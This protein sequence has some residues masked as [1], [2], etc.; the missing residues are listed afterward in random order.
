MVVP[1]SLHLSMQPLGIFLHDQGVYG[2]LRRDRA[3][4]G[5]VF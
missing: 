4:R 2:L 5:R 3:V 1:S